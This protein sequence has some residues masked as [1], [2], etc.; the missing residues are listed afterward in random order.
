MKFLQTDTG[1]D[2]DLDELFASSIINA[3]DFLMLKN[4][5]LDEEYMACE[6]DNFLRID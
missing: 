5:G 1:L 4:L 6:G 3:H 2:Y